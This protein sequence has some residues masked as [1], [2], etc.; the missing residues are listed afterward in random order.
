MGAHPAPKPMQ[1][2]TLGRTGLSVS[3]IGFGAA[4]LGNEFGDMD[5]SEGARAVQTAIDRGVNFFDTAPYYGRTLSEER[6]GRALEGRRHEVVLATKCCRY[7]QRGFDFSAERVRADI[8]AGLQRLRTDHVDLFQ[9]HDV[10]F[11]QA[12]QILQETL[13]AMREVQ[14]AGKA[15]FIGITGLPVEMLRSLAEEFAVDTVL[16]YCHY[17]LLDQELERVLGPLVDDQGLGLINASPLSMGLLTESE[18]Q[19]WHPAPQPL[20]DVCP[21]VAALCREHG[22]SVMEVALRYAIDNEHV[23]TTLSGIGS[24][25]QLEQNLTVLDKPNDP[26][27]LARIDALIDPVRNLTWHEGLAENAPSGGA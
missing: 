23:A 7:D 4:P 13:P 17:N 10:E 18:P 25:E 15:R 3:A 5:E 19:P 22:R 8:D 9:V 6:L 12:S 26:E 27:L 2:R 11:G 20:K 16:S 24:V 1:H 14:A 21:Q